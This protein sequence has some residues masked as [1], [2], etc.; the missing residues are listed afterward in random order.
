[1][2]LTC[3][4]YKLQF[5]HPFGV[6]SNT[7]KETASVFIKLEAEGQAG[8][9]EACLPAYLGE[10][11]AETISFFEK[12]KP[13][14]LKETMDSSLEDLL[15]RIDLLSYGCNAA[16]AAIDIALNDLFSKIAQKPYYDWMDIGKSAPMPTSF[17]IGI[18]APEKLEQK[19]KEAADFPVLKIKAG[20]ADDKSLITLIRRYTDKPLYVDVNQGWTDK[21]F[22]V[23]M[24]H[25]LHT[26][27]VILVEQPM[28]VALKDEMA[29]VTAQS[30][31]P[32][33]ADESVKRLSDLEQLKGVFSGV[34][35]KLMKCTGLNEALKMIRYCKQHQL[36]ILLGCM[37]ESSCAT[38]AMAQLMPFADHIDLDAPNLYK[39]DPFNGVTYKNGLV[40]LN[41]LPGIGAEP[42]HLLSRFN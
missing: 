14:L 22:V 16:K 37:A 26:Q 39:N 4:P 2:K 32:L 17:T 41:N 20:T 35:I 11:E 29:W 34:N 18:D 27:R 10:T 42:N 24:I 23:E 28:P 13:V 40:H 15:H 1:M 31:L 5:K 38:S 25:W 36:K 9:G 30:P 21:Y 7:R 33:I 19:I 12:A 3:T 8:Y 6:S